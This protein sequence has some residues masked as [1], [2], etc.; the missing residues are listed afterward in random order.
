MKYVTKQKMLSRV[1]SITNVTPSNQ[2]RRD[3]IEV[4]GGLTHTAGSALESKIRSFPTI[5]PFEDSTGVGI[6]MGTTAD[7]E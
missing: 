7:E 6:S 3:I 4:S 1:A 2:T 5:F